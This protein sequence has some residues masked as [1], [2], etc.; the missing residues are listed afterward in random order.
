[1]SIRNFNFRPNYQFS[2]HISVGAQSTFKGKTF[3]TEIY[4]YMKNNKMPE[5]YRP[6][7]TNS[8]ILGVNVSCAPP[9]L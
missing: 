9:P 8:R 7:N 2:F 1:M 3:L 4:V 5:F 6:K